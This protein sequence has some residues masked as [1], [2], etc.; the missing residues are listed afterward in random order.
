MSKKKS[1]VE[2]PKPH[3]TNKVQTSGVLKAH[4]TTS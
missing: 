1:T 2:L 4:T 3:P